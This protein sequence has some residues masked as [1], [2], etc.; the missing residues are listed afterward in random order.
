MYENLY[1]PRAQTKLYKTLPLALGIGY[2]FLN[3][4]SPCHCLS[5][6][7]MDTY[8]IGKFLLICFNTPRYFH[9]KCNDISPYKNIR[10]EEHT[11]DIDTAS[12]SPSLSLKTSL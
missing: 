9:K 3:V 12:F 4:S 11:M 1:K 7:Q 2:H 8:S 5:M 6:K 10:Q